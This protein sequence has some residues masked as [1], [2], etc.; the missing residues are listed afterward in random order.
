MAFQ[1][2]LKELP[3]ADIVQLVAVAGKTGTAQVV[4][5]DLN[6]GADHHGDHAWFAGYAPAENPTIVVTALV[7]NGGHGGV[8]AAPL[9]KQVMESYFG[10]AKDEKQ[11][12]AAEQ[13][14]ELQD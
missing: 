5:L 14:E 4:S 3:L 10:I 2:S 12:G 7:E 1:G 9:V 11:D 6:T 13:N 8:A